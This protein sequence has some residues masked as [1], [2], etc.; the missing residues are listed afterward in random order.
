MVWT[1]AKKEFHDNLLT[2]RF[3]FGSLILILLVLAI[4]L[5]SVKNYKDLNQEYMFSVQETEKKVK[6]KQGLF[7]H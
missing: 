2:F 3:S 4:T 5:A 6:G 1:V 7:H